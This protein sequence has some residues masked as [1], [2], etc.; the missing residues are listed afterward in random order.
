MLQYENIQKA[1]GV[2]IAISSDMAEA[3]YLWNRMYVNK[4]PWLNADVK[5]LNLPAAVCQEMARLVTMESKINISGSS[6]ADYISGSIQK[7]LQ[8][9]PN[10][11][12]LCCSGGGLVFKPYIDRDRVAIDIVRAGN[13]YPTAFDSSGETTGMVFPE[14]KRKGK[15]L[16]TRLEYQCLDGDRYIIINRAFKSRKASIKT[17]NIIQ[18]GQEIN[19][20]DVPEW[21]DLEPYV[22]LHN[23]TGTLFSHYKIPL[24]NNIDVDSPLGVSAYSRAVNQ[25]RDAD[26]QYGATM[27]EYKAKKTAIQAADDFFQKTRAGEVILPKGKERIYHAMG[28]DI[29]DNDGKPFYNVYSPDIRDQSFFNGYNRIV[30]KIEF[31]CGLAYGTLSDPQV[32]D[33]TAEEIKASKQRSYATVKAIQNSTED[34]IGGLVNAIDAWVTISGLQSAGKVEASYDWDDSLVVD[35]KSE[36]EQIR[37]DVSMGAMSLVEYRMR[38]FGETEEQATAMIPPPDTA[39][40]M[41]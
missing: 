2:D 19:L 36:I 18:L 22:E 29:R 38:R 27:W 35:K 26:E 28:G 6:R 12:E 9:L 5:S 40:V 13:F 7:F 16:F 32:I 14:F 20:S 39:E 23:A 34:A 25:I 41:P 3:I 30:Q 33:K 31:N 4:A 1:L 10:H 11:V 17:D 24:A 21:A 37:V 15:N 8:R